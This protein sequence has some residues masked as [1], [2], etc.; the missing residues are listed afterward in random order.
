MPELGR[1]FYF[2]RSCIL[3]CVLVAALPA[4]GSTTVT[5]YV[6]VN[7]IGYEAGTA[8]RAYLMASRRVSGVG[9][10]VT[11]AAAETVLTG[12]V[13]ATLGSWGKYNVYP[14]DFLVTTPGIYTV[15]VSGAVTLPSP[16]RYPE[17]DE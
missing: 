15:A 7:Q 6:R 2:S 8:M 10:A 16:R 5:G 1:R 9:F 4:F 13:G 11:N 12:S 17:P 14:I 3:F